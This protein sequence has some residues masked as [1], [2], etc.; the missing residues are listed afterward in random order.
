MWWIL[1]I[2]IS[3]TGILFLKN[4]SADSEKARKAISKSVQC[5]PR[6]A[7]SVERF[8]DTVVR[9]GLLMGL[10]MIVTPRK[11]KERSLPAPETPE[12]IA[13]DEV[14]CLLEEAKSNRESPL[15]WPMIYADAY[16]DASQTSSEVW[17]EFL[18]G[19]FIYA[20]RHNPAQALAPL[21]KAVECGFF[22]A[23]AILGDLYAEY[24]DTKRAIAIVRPASEANYAPAVHQHAYYIY[25]ESLGKMF[26]YRR[27]GAYRSLFCQ[28][29]RMGY[30]PSR[31]V[32]EANGWL[33]TS[34]C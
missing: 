16:R 13:Q 32:A 26:Q 25:L 22:P 31:F 2:L 34:S 7:I 11:R 18:Q 10:F 15:H 21:Q 24:G 19:V 9:K 1:T 17:E 6:T 4:G 20:H 28:S 14:L 3:F 5:C 33:S 29:A 8:R 30:Q 12:Y 23:Y 27:V